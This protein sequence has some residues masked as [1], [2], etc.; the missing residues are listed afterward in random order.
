M[1]E[2][3]IIKTRKYK[4]SDRNFVEDFQVINS[5]L[6]VKTKQVISNKCMYLHIH[7]YM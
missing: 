7:M 2:C 3:E 4:Q 5:E 6:K 1:Y